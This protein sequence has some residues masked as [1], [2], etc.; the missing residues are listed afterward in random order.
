MAIFPLPQDIAER[1]RKRRLPTEEDEYTTEPP[2]ALPA[3]EGPRPVP[4]ASPPGYTPPRGSTPPFARRQSRGEEIAEARD[5]YSEMPLSRG[6][7]ALKGALLGLGQ[8]LA[9]GQGLGGALGGALA[10]AAGGALSPK[11]IRRQ[12]FET[13][14]RPRIEERFGYEDQDRA[15]AQAEYQQQR[16]MGL[17][18]MNAAKTQAEIGEINRRNLPRPE[19]GP[20][21]RWEKGINRRTGQPGFYNV[22]DPAQA[23]EFEPFQEERKGFSPHWIETPQ[24]YVNLNDPNVDPKKVRKLQR[25]KAA[26]KPKAGK[27]YAAITDIRA[28]AEKAGVSESQMAAQF[29][30]AGYEIVR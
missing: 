10:G 2:S 7:G 22:A 19:R 1:L 20:A 6:R 25:P 14:I 18:A 21:P 15:I 3:I 27:K 13:Q 23:A 11:T 30:S 12:E 5:A 26:A 28:A 16:Q 24:G 17:D 29:K 4:L 8:G 9:T